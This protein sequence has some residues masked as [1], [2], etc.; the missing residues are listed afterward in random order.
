M[1]QRSSIPSPSV[2]QVHLGPLTVHFYALCI[3]AGIGVAIWLSD[4]RWVARGGRPGDVLDIATWGVPFGIVGARLYHV[5]TD[6]E[7]YFTRGQNP[8]RAFAIWDGGLG[9]WGAIALGALGTWIGCRRR[10]IKLAPFGDAV[11][12]GIALAQGIGRLGNW[13][14][15]EL[16]GGHTTLPWAVHITNP[17]PGSAPGYYHPTFLYELLW[18]VAVALLVIGVDRRWRLGHGR[19]FA[20]YVAAYTV[21][22]AWIEWLRVDHAN[23]ILGL[24]LNDWTSLLVFLGA[25]TYLVL[26]RHRHREQ[27]DEVRQDSPEP[28]APV[29]VS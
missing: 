10:G 8:W 13:F 11:A 26:T 9:V 25:C 22:R 5:L 6:P 3:L 29:P 27:P 7:L 24:R 15:Q 16:F 12:P 1:L 18:D 4:R 20:L 28:A 14:N 2:S 17:P 21:G 19:A 23:H